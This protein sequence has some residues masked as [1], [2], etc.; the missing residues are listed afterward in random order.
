M[1]MRRRW[2][3]VAILV[4]AAAA[5][6]P[7]SDGPVIISDFRCPVDGSNYTDN[8]GPRADGSFHYGIDMLAP[9]GTP[10]WAVKPGNV[11]YDWETAGGLVAY[12][13]ADGGNVY[14]YAHMSDTVGNDRRVGQGDAIGL[15]GETGNA[16]TPHLHFEMRIGSVTAH[17]TDPYA[18][19]KNAGC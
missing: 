17:G 2:F 12:L 19:L 16:T 13:F 15:V 18:T 1:R 9:T 10:L 7:S 6:F 5:C 4:V 8:Y 3:A 11:H 14:Y